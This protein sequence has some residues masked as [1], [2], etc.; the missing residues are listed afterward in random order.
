VNIPSTLQKA[1]VNETVFNERLTQL[2]TN[3]FE[4]QCTTTN[5]RYPLIK[6]LKEILL[7]AYK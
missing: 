5:P 7:K 6:E 3:A 4:D 2:A 1:G